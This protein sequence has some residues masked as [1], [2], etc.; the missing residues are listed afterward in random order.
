[1]RKNASAEDPYT[2]QSLLGFIRHLYKNQEYYRAFVEL[3]RLDAYWPGYLDPG[4]LHIARINF[5]MKSRRYDDVVKEQKAK[6][7]PFACAS[8]IFYRDAELHLVRWGA[9]INKINIEKCEDFCFFFWKRDF[10]SAILRGDEKEARMMLS[11][12]IFPKTFP[13]EKEK[14]NGILERAHLWRQD[15]RDPYLALFAGVIPGL[16]YISGGNKP[17]GVLAFIVIGVF[18]S[19][20]AAAYKTE[21]RPIGIC[22]GTVAGFFYGGSILGGYMTAK[23]HN[24]QIE[25]IIRQNAIEDAELEKDR[26]VIF[27]KY[28]L[29]R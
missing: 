17:T 8:E 12:S 1:M 11:E 14:F 4:R 7:Y 21:N 28:G 25:K 5:L 6:N 19:L 9:V 15:M 29:P 3:E 24:A 18:S 23:R 10:I 13:E 26:E 2:P 22:L 27:E 20:A 16:G